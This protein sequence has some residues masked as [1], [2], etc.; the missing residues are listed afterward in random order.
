MITPED[1]RRL[2]GNTNNPPEKE[3]LHRGRMARFRG[4]LGMGVFTSPYKSIAL[5]LLKALYV[6]FGSY[7]VYYTGLLG[8][9]IIGLMGGD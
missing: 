2:N 1:I 8:I 7:A 6:I 9:F 5:V 3:V 4:L